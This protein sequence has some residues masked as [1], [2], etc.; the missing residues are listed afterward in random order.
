MHEDIGVAT[1]S[2]MA[3]S[4]M[5]LSIEG[6]HVTLTINVGDLRLVVGSK[7]RYEINRLPNASYR[8]ETLIDIIHLTYQFAYFHY[9]FMF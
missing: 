4:I 6:I 2:I 3:F 5:T 1:L 8:N 9:L 7:Y